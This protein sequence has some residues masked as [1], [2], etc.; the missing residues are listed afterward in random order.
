[1]KTLN[2]PSLFERTIWASVLVAG[3]CAPFIPYTLAESRKILFTLSLIAIEPGT[4]VTSENHDDIPRAA[5]DA[6][7]KFPSKALDTNDPFQVT[8]DQPGEYNDDCGLHAHVNAKSL[9]RYKRKG[10]CDERTGV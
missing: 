9:W 4:T 8:F 6:A 5:V 1:V 3:L 10:P 7:G 2:A